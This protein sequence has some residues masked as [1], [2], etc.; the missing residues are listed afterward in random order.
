MKQRIEKKVLMDVAVCNICKKEIERKPWEHS[1]A[2]KRI[3]ILNGLFKTS[4]F[5]AH[6]RCVNSV[7]RDTFK[8]YL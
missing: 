6:E 1:G 3:A 2:A 7:M 4:N 5:D 8:K